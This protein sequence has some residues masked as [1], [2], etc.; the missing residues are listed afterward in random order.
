MQLATERADR[1]EIETEL[2]ELKQK[3]A[4]AS[5]ELPEAATL[6]NQSKKAKG[7]KFTA[8]LADVE[9][10]LEMVEEAITK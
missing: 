8:S 2:S 6:L 3:S 4:A 10:I 5:K 1:K 9:L 7:K